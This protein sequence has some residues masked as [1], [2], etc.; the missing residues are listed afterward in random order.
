MMGTDLFIDSKSSLAELISS[1]ST[2]PTISLDTEFMRESTYYPKLCLIQIATPKLAAC[3]DCLADLD[4]SPLF[5]L[6]LEKN[7][8][9]ILHSSRQDLEVIN[10]HANGLP[11]HLI[12]TQIAAAL[13]GHPPQIGLQDITQELLNITLDKSLTR[14]NW[15]KRPLATAAVEY[16]L[17]DVH[18]LLRLWD[19]LRSELEKHGRI[20]WF[21]EDCQQALGAPLVTPS[22]ALW[23]RLR[24]LGSLEAQSQCA[25]LSLVE[26]R[27]QC[28]KKRDRPRR[29]ILSDE[30]LLRIASRLPTTHEELASIAE[31]PLQFIKRFG[32]EILA[33]T[34][35]ENADKMTLVKKRINKSRPD[36]TD[37]RQLQDHTTQ[38]AHEL[39]VQPEVLATRKE[40]AELLVGKY[41]N[42]I[43]TGWRWY[44]FS[45]FCPK[46]P[47]NPDSSS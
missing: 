37:L 43:A 13:L 23:E 39:G 35:H 33:T 28:A 5:E 19:R 17:H 18:H 22:F 46:E 36:K 16:A 2:E 24:G 44:E 21:E 12:D 40:L 20:N 6:L 34:N 8:T 11:T 9:W 4:F 41:S 47:Q 15:A 3:I 29:W 25:A 10:Q 31:M 14:T 26:W 7:R 45:S 27:E 32:D 1:I 38:R 30:L 42:R